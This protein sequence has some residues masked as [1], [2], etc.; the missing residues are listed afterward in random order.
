MSDELKLVLLRVGPNG[1]YKVHA[2]ATTMAIPSKEW[3]VG[4]DMKISFRGPIA[5][6]V[7]EHKTP[8]SHKAGWPI[9]DF[10]DSQ[11]L[12]WTT[13]ARPKDAGWSTQNYEVDC[14]HFAKHFQLENV[15]KLPVSTSEFYHNHHSL[16]LDNKKL[17]TCFSS[18]SSWLMRRGEKDWELMKLWDQWT[19]GSL[20]QNY[21]DQM[22]ARLYKSQT[23][24]LDFIFALCKKRHAE[25]TISINT[26]RSSKYAEMKA[27][28]LTIK[29]HRVEVEMPFKVETAIT[30]IMLHDT[31]TGKYRLY[32]F[33]LSQARTMIEYAYVPLRKDGSVD[34][35]E[36]KISALGYQHIEGL[37]NI[38]RDLQAFLSGNQLSLLWFEPNS[39]ESLVWKVGL[40]G[41]D[42]SAPGVCGQV[43]P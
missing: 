6:R 21:E 36:P 35:L 42:G 29:W 39:A 43:R 8:C 27:D 7:P 33:H 4:E 40:I 1:G 17:S 34:T 19:F 2:Y 5:I 22:Y 23:Y 32:M 18:E 31:T 15:E 14:W 9:F 25:Q 12:I 37:P 28:D 38:A 24:N 3:P 11:Q 16:V 10:Q 13:Y 26:I 30:P 20:G 41:D